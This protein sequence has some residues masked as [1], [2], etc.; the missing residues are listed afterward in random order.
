MCQKGTKNAENS[1]KLIF[2]FV[3]IFDVIK[4]RI[5]MINPTNQTAV[6]INTTITQGPDILSEVE[7]E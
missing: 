1:Y 5:V 6:S 3:D 7:Y 2:V 4:S